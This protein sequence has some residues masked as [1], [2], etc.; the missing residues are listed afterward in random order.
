MAKLRIL[1]GHEQKKTT[2]VRN[3]NI[4]KF[5]KLKIEKI[6]FAWE[7]FDKTCGILEFRVFVFFNKN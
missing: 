4:S 5:L 6:N 7:I 3:S 1:T 2:Q